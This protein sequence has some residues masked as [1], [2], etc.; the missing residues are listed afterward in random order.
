MPEHEG[1][2]ADEG[3]PRQAVA[4]VAEHRRDAH[5]SLRRRHMARLAAP[6]FAEE[7][8]VPPLLIVH[9][10]GQRTDHAAIGPSA[11]VISV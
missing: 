11:S 5:R 4:I 2:A 1:I 7:A 6:A 10:L 9:L 3:V 8:A